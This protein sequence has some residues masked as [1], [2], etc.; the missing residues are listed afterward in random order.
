V[1]SFLHILTNILLPQNTS[2]LCLETLVTHALHNLY[3]S[4]NITR[5]TKSKAIVRVGHAARM[6][7]MTDIQKAWKGVSTWETDIDRRVVLR[8]DHSG[9]RMWGGFMRLRIRTREWIGGGIY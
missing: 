2:A 4:P 9:V 8:M 6:W 5:V 1:F 7:E 3:S